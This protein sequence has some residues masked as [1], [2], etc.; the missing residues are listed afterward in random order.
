MKTVAHTLSG[1]PTIN[2]SYDYDAAGNR[3]SMTDGLGSVTYTRNQ[4]SQLTAETRTFTGVGSFTVNYGYNLAGLLTSVTDPFGAQ[5]GYTHDSVG[6]TT[7]VTGSNF[8]SVSTYASGLQY[9]AWGALKSLNYGNAKTMAMTYDANLRA[10][11]YEI[12]GLMKKSYQYYNDG[13]L[14]FTQDQ[15]ITNSKFDRLYRYDH[16]GRTTMGLTGLEA[17]EQG[18]TND[19][20][21]KETMA[22]DAWVI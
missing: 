3:T 4:L 21:Y 1:S 9:R 18:T 19:R 17:R 20:P 5:V 22:Y 12:P 2:V 14:R 15:L 16:L 13:R 10:A 8:A 6:R 7:A 11:T